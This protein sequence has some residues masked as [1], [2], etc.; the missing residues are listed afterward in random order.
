MYNSLKTFSRAIYG[1]NLVVNSA[2]KSCYCGCIIQTARFLEV[3]VSDKRVKI[4]I[5]ILA[6]VHTNRQIS[7]QMQTVLK[8]PILK[9]RPQMFRPRF[10][11]LN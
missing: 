3:T 1:P 11:P 10:R 9:T 8:P 5:F 7:M 6:R 2:V 4:F